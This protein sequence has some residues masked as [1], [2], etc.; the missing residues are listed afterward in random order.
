MGRR[1]RKFQIQIICSDLICNRLRVP[2]WVNILPLVTISKVTLLFFE[3]K[4]VAD[5]F[6]YS[7]VPSQYSPLCAFQRRS[8]F[9]NA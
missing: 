2:R 4:E 1:M 5:P 3:L 7:P 8:C 9:F 6:D